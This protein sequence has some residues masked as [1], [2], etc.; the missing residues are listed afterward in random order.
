MNTVLT[1]VLSDRADRA[2][3]APDVADLLSGVRARVVERAHRRRR[4]VAAGGGAA[5]AVAAV[6]G[7]S[8]AV[9]AH[10]PAA[11]TASTGAAAGRRTAAE[12]RRA[13][14]TPA[15]AR[16]AAERAL[17]AEAA[18]AAAAEARAATRPRAARSIE[19]VPIAPAPA[20]AEVS[21]GLAPRGW[22][23][24]GAS[25]AATT[26]GPASGTN[27]DPNDFVG[28]LAVLVGERYD[29][30]GSFP[31][32]IA[33]RPGRLD[34]PRGSDTTVVTVPITAKV[35]VTIQVPH[36]TGLDQDQI[37][38]LADTLDVRSTAHYGV[39]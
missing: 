23:Y 24:L 16:A 14:G 12:H 37:L 28:K 26:Y 31:L 9:T 5:L 36:A 19:L 2:G 1:D 39:G 8:A 4:V 11:R 6:V 18:R 15:E 34:D 38:R 25:D 22:E 29:Q 20:S 33:G 3:S 21:L 27:H 10:D 13:S 35:E 17:A 32:R 7:V 30:A